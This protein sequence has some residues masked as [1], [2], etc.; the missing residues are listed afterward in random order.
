MVGGS[1]IFHHDFRYGY[2]QFNNGFF[3]IFGMNGNYLT[4]IGSF[5]IDFK[6]WIKILF[7]Y[8]NRSRV[9]KELQKA[10]VFFTN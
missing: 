8:V 2:K 4:G 9:P 3:N 10:Y 6:S 5:L 1:N 7:Y